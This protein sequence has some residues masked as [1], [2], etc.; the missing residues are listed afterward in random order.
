VH[1]TPILATA[2]NQVAQVQDASST[3]KRTLTYRS[4]G[5]L[6]QDAVT[7]GA[8]YNYGYNARKR[9]VS[10]GAVSGNAGTYGYDYLGRR[11]WRTVVGSSATVQTHYIFDEAG[12]LIA[13]HDGATGN[14]LREYVWL[15]DTPIAMIDSTGTSPAT[16]FIHTGQIEEPLVMTD[17]TKAKVWGAYVEPFGRATVFGT[18]SA[19]LDLRLPGQFT[20][21]ETGALSQNWNRDYDTSLGRYIQ[22]DPLGIEAGQNVYGY[23]D[24]DPLASV[25]VSGLEQ[26]H[27]YGNWGGP[28][29][30]NG[31]K[32][33]EGTD[34]LPRP[35]D[36]SY[37][38]PIDAQD[39]C[40]ESH[41]RCINR[42]DWQPGVKACMVRGAHGDQGVRMCD[43]K[44]SRCLSSLK[45]KSIRSSSTSVAFGSVIPW[46]V[47]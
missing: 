44:L 14:V 13:E 30:A 36:P 42:S 5:D 7:S 37:R 4:G 34:Y 11:V 29:W 21:V 16:Y 1:E 3:V 28:G 6:S 47:H 8:T 24:G 39:A 40:Y 31:Q 23:V 17:A 38:P 10:A 15:D 33:N 46:L 32:L 45:K 25:D 18:P 2:S 41:D 9:L 22:A 43:A 26:F 20:Q 35:G 19:G 12:H 27:Y